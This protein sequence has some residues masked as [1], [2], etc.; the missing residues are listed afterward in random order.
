MNTIVILSIFG[1]VFLMLEALFFMSCFRWLSNG[2]KIREREFMRLDQER[3]EL[4]ELQQSVSME[5]AQ[6]K[7]ISEETLSKL[8]RVGA[9]AH[10]EWT[11]MTHKCE[12]L[13]KELE[14]KSR[15]LTETSISHVNRQRMQLE[16]SV[17]IASQTSSELVESTNNAKRLLRFLDENVPSD[18]ILKELQAE[19][20]AEARRL[21]Q[22]GK[23]LGTIC[24][25]LGLSQSEVQ[26]LSYMG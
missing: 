18:E 3:S 4:V 16:K 11:E 20:Y 7:K 6:A 15:E 19:K 13:L 25:K 5:L 23:E 1:F 12:S 17:Q 14:D 10:A 2:K 26:L 9:D 24:R 22:E 8:K 21:I